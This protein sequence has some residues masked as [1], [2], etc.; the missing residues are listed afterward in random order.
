[1]RPAPLRILVL[2]LC[3]SIPGAARAQ[4]GDEWFGP[5]KKKHFGACFVLAGAGYAGGALLFDAP[6]A[7]WL[8]GAG[9]AMGAGVGK[10]LYDKQRG[11]LFSFKDLA[12]DGVGTVTGLGVSYLVDRLIFGRSAPDSGDVAAWRRGGLGGWAAAGL[13][14]HEPHQLLAVQPWVHRH[15]GAAPAGAAAG[16]EDGDLAARALAHAAGGQDADVVAQ[17][18]LGQRA[19][20]PAW[21][22]HAA[23]SGAAAHQALAAD[24]HLH[25]RRSTA[26]FVLHPSSSGSPP[27]PADAPV[28]TPGS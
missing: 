1:M 13:A 27:R 25:L 7:R 3:L 6:A 17:A 5:D 24:E 8:T 12:W 4:Y 15:H 20:E 28:R 19:L 21:Q 16:D 10:E 26:A 22:V 23:A 14:L 11:G 2:L 18:P 9:L